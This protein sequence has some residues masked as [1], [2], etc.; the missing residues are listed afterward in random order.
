MPP[1]KVEVAVEVFK[2][3]PPLTSSPCERAREVPEIPP[4]NDEVE[5]DVTL[6]VPLDSN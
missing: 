6:S 1:E 2:I 3:E 5:T 4:E